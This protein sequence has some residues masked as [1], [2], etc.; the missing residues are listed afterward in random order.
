MP[1]PDIS[2]EVYQKDWMPGFA[3]FCNDGSIRNN[4]HAHVVL[5]LGCLMRCIED[6]DLAPK[7]IPYVVA[8]CLMHET[9][10]A[11]AAGMRG[12]RA[13]KRTR[14]KPKS[15]WPRNRK[16]LRRTPFKSKRKPLRRQKRIPPFRRRQKTRILADGREFLSY[17]DWMARRR[18]VWQRDGQ[19][20]VDCRK[21]LELNEAEIHHLR[22]RSL[23]GGDQ[24]SNLVTLCKGPFGCHAKRH[25]GANR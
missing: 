10:H 21:K 2:I 25:A 8:E 20:C 13:M 17:R 3:A 11:L 24:G 22:K 16:P 15:K 1:K 18:E 4:A 5:N 14:L 23:R 12:K 6:K 9:I 19:R 7:E